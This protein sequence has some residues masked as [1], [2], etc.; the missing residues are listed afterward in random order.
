MEKN[1]YANMEY[2]RRKKNQGVTLSVLLLVFMLGTASVFI[3]TKQYSFVIIFGAVAILPIFLLPSIFKNY[4]TDN[5]VMVAIKDREVSMDGTT[6]KLNNITKI[7]VT[8]E[9]PASR[10]DSENK[11]TLSKVAKEKPEDIYFGNFDL[12]VKDDMGK[13]KVLYSHIDNVID[14]LNTL[15]S[16]GVKHYEIHYTIKKQSVICEYDLRKDMAIEKEKSLQSTSKKDRK[17]QLL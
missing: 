17:K 1:Y 9:L 3:A 6:C 4:P 15:L 12:V 11:I 8:V 10:L 16:L 13:K 7:R 5:R 14:A 2:N